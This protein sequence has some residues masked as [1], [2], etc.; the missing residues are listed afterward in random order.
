[1]NG[2]NPPGQFRDAR[3]DG[4]YLL[5]QLNR[6][7]AEVGWS[8]NGAGFEEISGESR[9]KR[10]RG[11]RLADSGRPLRLSAGLFDSILG[12]WLA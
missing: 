2:E 8:A 7:P 11:D 9:S 4:G 6:D 1:M 5:F 10:V 12:D 3:C